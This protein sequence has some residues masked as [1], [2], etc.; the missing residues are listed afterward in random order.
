MEWN[1]KETMNYRIKTKIY[2]SGRKEYLAQK[3]VLGIWFNLRSDGELVL[4]QNGTSRPYALDSIENNYSG[5]HRLDKTEVEYVVKGF[6]RKVE[7]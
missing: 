6:F 5:N 2:K 1:K 4:S 7:E 3:K